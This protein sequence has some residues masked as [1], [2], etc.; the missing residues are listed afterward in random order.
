MIIATGNSG[1]NWERQGT[2]AEIPNA[3]LEAVRAVDSLAVWAVGGPSNGYGVILRTS[4]GGQ[5]WDR[6]GSWSTLP[7]CGFNGIS[8]LDASTAWVVGMNNTILYTSNGGTTWANA[9][10]PAYS[11]YD[12]DFVL[13]VDHS[14]VWVVGGTESDGII[15][16]SSDGGSTWESQGN[17]ELLDGYPLI[18]ISA[19]NAQTAMIVGHGHTVAR[20]SDG[21]ETW[22]LCVPDSLPRN[23][24]AD[25][26]NGVVML[27]T[28]WAL[29][30][31]DY[32]KIYI[33]SNG[34]DSWNRQ[35]IPT[36][37][38][39]FFYLDC[40]AI[41]QNGIW[42]A[43]HIPGAGDGVI[44]HTSNGGAE[45]GLQVVNDPGNSGFRDVHF[46]GSHH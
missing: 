39:G 25:D 40:C 8:V 32:G 27:S 42:I 38:Q 35:T 7:H 26:A 14:H 24:Q 20:T 43:G 37:A 9:A 12:Y 16:H 15:L 22:E 23:T 36:A 3:D 46:A 41:D 6:Q 13:A 4:D 29:V 31:M 28:E 17:S 44:L 2:V 21:G 45:W 11:G 18:S 1:V 19:F 10:D 30:S 33:T 34:G 5:T